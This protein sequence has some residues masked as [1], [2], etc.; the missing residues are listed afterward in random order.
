MITQESGAAEAR[1]GVHE[2]DLEASWMICDTMC[3]HSEVFETTFRVPMRPLF[4]I[5]ELI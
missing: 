5:R 3:V 2:G 1:N 4:R